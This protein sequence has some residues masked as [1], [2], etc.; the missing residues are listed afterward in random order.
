MTLVEV[1][2]ASAVLT[3]V[4]G[5]VITT[6][7]TSTRLNYSS[8][9]HLAAFGL[10][11]GRLEQMRSL[12]FGDITAANFSSETL[13]LTHMGGATRHPLP[14]T[15]SSTLTHQMNPE[16]QDVSIVV[17]WT[18]AGMDLEERITTAIYRKE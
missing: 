4:T 15:R 7:V 3:V 18:F 16:R 10:C 2:I 1:M 8:A 9:Q 17:A 11:E 14:C 5:A 13:P 6:V 12:P